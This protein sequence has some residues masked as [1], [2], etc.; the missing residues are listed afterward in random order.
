MQAIAKGILPPDMVLPVIQQLMPNLSIP[1]TMQNKTFAQAAQIQDETIAM[2][3]QQK[4][5]QQ[6]GQPPQQEGVPEEQAEPQQEP[7]QQEMAEQV[8]HRRKPEPVRQCAPMGWSGQH[9]DGV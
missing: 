3:E 5:Q 7:Q 6:N 1:I 8:L 9:K 2:Q 4:Q